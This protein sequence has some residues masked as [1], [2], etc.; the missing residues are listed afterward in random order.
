M[1]FYNQLNLS[2]SNFIQIGILCFSIAVLK[3][4]AAECHYA[5]DY[6]YSGRLV[7]KYVPISAHNH[8]LSENIT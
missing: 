5:I 1:L 3:T 4:W 7:G 2:G 6:C 8:K